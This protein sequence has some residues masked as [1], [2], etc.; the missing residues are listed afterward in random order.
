MLK[1]INKSILKDSFFKGIYIGSLILFIYL[2]G[3]KQNFTFLSVLLIYLFSFIIGY[4]GTRNQI[5]YKRFNGKPRK[6]FSFEPLIFIWTPIKIIILIIIT[7]IS[8]LFFDF[9][10]TFLIIGFTML[11]MAIIQVYFQHKKRNKKIR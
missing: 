5:K 3:Y 6:I 11:I 1:P 9:K 10:I 4:I 2:F 7:L 8:Y